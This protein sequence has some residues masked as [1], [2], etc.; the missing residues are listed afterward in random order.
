MLAGDLDRGARG[1]CRDEAIYAGAV[2]GGVEGAR[3]I[4]NESVDREA[5]ETRVDGGPARAAVGRGEDAR[6][7]AGIQDGIAPVEGEGEDRRGGEP[8]VACRPRAAAV[9]AAPGA[10]RGSRVQR[11]GRGRIDRQRKNRSR[12]KAGG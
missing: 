2:S 11:A 1:G 12:G 4:E 5:R 10:A 8:G 6:G 9:V 7:R 3:G